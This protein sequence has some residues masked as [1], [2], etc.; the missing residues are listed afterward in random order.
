MTGSADPLLVVH[1]KRW[2]LLPLAAGSLVFVAIGIWMT[3]EEGVARRG[4]GLSTAFWGWLCVL[5]FGFCFAAFATQMLKSSPTLQATGE[6]LVLNLPFSSPKTVP[7]QSITGI[8]VNRRAGQ[9][10]LSIT[11]N[12][13]GQEAPKAARRRKITVAANLMSRPIEEV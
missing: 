11:L 3:G 10:F 7:W 8:E 13:E 4:F 6:G 2:G 9:A 5:F 1:P 12:G